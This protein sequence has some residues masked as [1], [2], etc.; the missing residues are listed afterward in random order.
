MG[1]SAGTW[2]GLGLEARAAGWNKGLAWGLGW[3]VLAKLGWDGGGDCTLSLGADRSQYSNIFSPKTVQ[4]TQS[5]MQKSICRF[6]MVG[7]AVANVWLGVAGYGGCNWMTN[8]LTSNCCNYFYF[9]PG[10]DACSTTNIYGLSSLAAMGQGEQS[11]WN[12]VVANI[13]TTANYFCQLN[14]NSK[15][16]Y[17]A[18]FAAN[19]Y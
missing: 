2:P 10:T 16:I 18:C 12:M 8:F 5:Q 15:L 14:N 11:L 3:L 13:S 6:G 1:C 19:L 9:Q 17:L 7:A 4:P